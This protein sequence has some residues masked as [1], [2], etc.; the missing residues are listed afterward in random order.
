MPLKTI[1]HHRKNYIYHHVHINIAHS[2]LI[3]QKHSP[4]LP[5][6]YAR[7]LL[8]L[9]SQRFSIPTSPLDSL[10][11]HACHIPHTSCQLSLTILIIQQAVQIIRLPILHP[12]TTYC[13][14]FCLEFRHSYDPTIFKHPQ[15]TNS[16]KHSPLSIH[17]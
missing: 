5:S 7:F 17:I 16:R 4:H 12:S 1:T 11:S 13:H 15:S 14:L 9:S 6:I 10:L 3:S 2:P 8:I